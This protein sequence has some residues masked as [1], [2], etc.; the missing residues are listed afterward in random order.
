MDNLIEVLQ[1]SVDKKPA[2]GEACNSCGFC[3]LTEVCCVGQEL[4]GGAIGPCKLL[5]SS[6]GK[7]EH[8]CSLVQK[9]P[10]VFAPLIGAGS[11]CCAKTQAEVFKELMP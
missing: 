5:T 2:F 3:C 7:G 11:G 9:K 6:L 10:E 1:L 4:G 8:Y